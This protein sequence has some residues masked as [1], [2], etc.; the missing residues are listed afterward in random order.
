MEYHSAIKSKDIMNF[1]GKW[2]ELEYII[3]KEVT[4]T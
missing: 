2:M 4:Q 1:K 3:L